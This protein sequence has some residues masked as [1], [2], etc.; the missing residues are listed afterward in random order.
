M[1]YRDLE[2]LFFNVKWEG[3]EGKTTE[4]KHR[5]ASCKQFEQSQS[6]EFCLTL[7]PSA[8]ITSAIIMGRKP[9]LA[10]PDTARTLT[11]IRRAGKDIF[12]LSLGGNVCYDKVSCFPEHYY[13]N[14]DCNTHC[15]P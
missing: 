4:D 12:F 13:Q 11:C 7:L 5:G 14:Y 10:V 1:V 9:G 3:N 15:L 2:V 6:L 8:R